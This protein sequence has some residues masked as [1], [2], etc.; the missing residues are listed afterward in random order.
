MKKLLLSLVAVAACFTMQAKTVEDVINIDCFGFTSATSYKDVTYTST[1]TGITYT[2]NMC[3]ANADNGNC[4]QFRSKSGKEAGLIVGANPKGYKLVSIKVENYTKAS[5]QNQWDVYGSTTAYTNFKDLYTATTAGTSIGNGTTTKTLTSDAGYTFFG[6]RPNNNAIYLTTITITYEESGSTPDPLAPAELK[7]PES[8]YTVELGETFDAPELTKA[9]T[10]A[11]T[12]DSS[13]KEVAT[14]DANSG[15]V[16]IMAVGTT[17]ITATTPE[18]TEFHAGEAKYTLEVTAHVNKVDVTLAKGVSTGKYIIACEKGVA[19]NYDGKNQ[20]YGYVYLDTKYVPANGNLICPEEYIFV[21]TSTPK[22][23]TIQG[24]DEGKFYG[25]D[26][27]HKT[28]FNFY[29]SA[30]ATGSN[31]YW[32][33]TID[34]DG[35]A[36]ITNKGRDGFYLAWMPFNSDFELV[37][38]NS[39]TG[40]IQLYSNG[41]LT[42][43]DDIVSDDANAPVEY[44]N[45]QGVRV[46][47]PES[48]LYIRVQGKKA[49]KVLVK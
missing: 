48:G 37:T 8:S 35:N 6:I 43:V 21:I 32:D 38:T 1:A 11:V 39:D 33:I 42:G 28:S 30:D 26:A 17:T 29:N 46:A 24:A 22:G 18:T 7:F 25:M 34:T 20:N 41:T 14:V 5:T 9:T 49:S 16:T 4:M 23:F 3:K 40:K 44:Y 2:G 27:K 10:A 13:N 31:C 12:Y 19:K 47:N 45:L 36:N 15:A